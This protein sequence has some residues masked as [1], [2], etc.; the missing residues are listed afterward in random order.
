VKTSFI[1]LDYIQS[2]SEDRKVDKAAIEDSGTPD[3]CS[4]SV[5]C[6]TR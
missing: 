4:S 2:A 3:S 5:Q 6:E 1:Q